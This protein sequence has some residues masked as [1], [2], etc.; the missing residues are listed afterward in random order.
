MQPAW[1]RLPHRPDEADT[2]LDKTDYRATIPRFQPEALARNLPI[3]EL[4]R[5]AGAAHGVKPAQVALS[6]LQTQRPYIVPIPD[7]TM[8]H[9]VEENLV[10]AAIMLTRTKRNQ[11][12][13]VWRCRGGRSLFSGRQGDGRI[14]SPKNGTHLKRL[15]KRVP[16]STFDPLVSCLSQKSVSVAAAYCCINLCLPALPRRP[17]RIAERWCTKKGQD[18]ALESLGNIFRSPAE[19]QSTAL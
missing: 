15:G 5:R 17:L 2:R 9:R 14:G 1:Q 6:W 13:A 11:F 18:W 8:L 4:F 3:V 19:A 12:G 16:A 7:T 10:A